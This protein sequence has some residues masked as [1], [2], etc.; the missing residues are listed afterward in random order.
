MEIYLRVETTL[1]SLRVMTPTNGIVQN[2]KFVKLSKKET[3]GEKKG[4]NKIP[5]NTTK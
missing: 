4:E 1:I 2:Q 5:C 3:L